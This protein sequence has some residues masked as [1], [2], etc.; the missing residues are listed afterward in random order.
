M[1][2]P[3]NWPLVKREAA[4]VGDIRPAHRPD[5]D[6]LVKSAIDACNGIIFIDD[7]Q[8]CDLHCAKHYAVS[9]KLV[10]TVFPLLGGAR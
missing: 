6:N 10:L 1:Q 9:P 5:L 3:P 2:I 4:I 8:I 7:G